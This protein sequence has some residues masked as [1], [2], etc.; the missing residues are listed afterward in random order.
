MVLRKQTSAKS[1]DYCSTSQPKW[2]RAELFPFRISASRRC[3]AR[4]IPYV[5]TCS[6]LLAAFIDHSASS[7]QPSCGTPF[8][9][10]RKGSLARSLSLSLLKFRPALSSVRKGFRRASAP[11]IVAVYVGGCGI[12]ARRLRVYAAFGA[13][14]TS[15]VRPCSTIS[16]A[17][18]TMTLSHRTR[19]TLRS[20]ETNK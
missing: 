12:A 14:S 16:P 10:C 5:G 15:S 3:R 9:E 1:F 18:M 17:C 6:E 7:S 11:R 20:W 2:R 13:P 19:T 8:Q 4:Q